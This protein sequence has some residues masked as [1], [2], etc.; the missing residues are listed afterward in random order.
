MKAIVFTIDALIALG[1]IIGVISGLI[2]FRTK[3]ASPL[4]ASQQLHFIS[5]DILTVLSNSKLRDVVD[6]QTLLNQYIT[7]GILNQTDLDEKTIDVIGALWSSGNISEAANLTKDILDDFVPS[8]I[9]YEFLINNDPIYNSSD[10]V[11]P[12]YE[13]STIEISSGRIVSGYERGKSTE[14]YVARA[15]ARKISK[16][17]TLV[18]MGDIITSS[19]ESAQNKI[20]VSYIA[21]IPE[22]AT[23]LD[24]YWFIEATW[25]IINKFSCYMNGENIPGCEGA[26]GNTKL[27]SGDYIHL[28]QPGHNIG[29]ISYRKYASEPTAGDDGATHLVIVY[30]TSQLTTLVDFGRQYLQNTIS[31]ASIEYRKPI[32]TVGEIYNMS[33]HINLTNETEVKNV[34]AKFMWNGETYDINIKNVTNGTVDWNDTEIKNVLNSNGIS[35]NMLTGRFFWF[36]FE[37]DPY[38]ENEPI[39]YERKIVGEDS[40]IALNYS[41]LIDIGAIYNYIDMTRVL[42]D[43]IAEDVDPNFGVSEFYRY[44]RWDFNLTSKI[45][46]MARWQYPWG[47]WDGYDPLQLARANDITVYNHDPSNASSDPFIKAF[48]RFGYD[49]NPEGVMISGDNKFELNFSDGYSI[50]PGDS[51]GDVTFLV[52]ASVGYGET[53]ENETD[54]IDDAVIRLEDILGDDISAM[55]MVVDAVRVS[56]V[57]YM[58]GPFSAR[59]RTWV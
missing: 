18:V 49:T 36:I 28:L 16:N 46:L 8:N 14:G 3:V 37:I 21:D 55:E 51:F 34:T 26:I 47:H 43:Y 50:N 15:I 5:E 6:N 24:T 48:A 35:Y 19:V 44:I 4:L 32:F 39:S 12:S 20:N 22:D 33:I 52:P 41:Q 9:G 13:N 10:T 58:W 11:R 38:H 42:E 56:G 31:E 2:F 1:I 30:N 17:N 23:I 27:E 29:H 53:F 57:P 25:G 7:D 45:P 59:V 40:Y 54:A